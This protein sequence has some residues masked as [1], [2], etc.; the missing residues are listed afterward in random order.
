MK[1]PLTDLGLDCEKR[2]IPKYFKVG[3]EGNINYD[4]GYNEK[5]SE[6]QKAVLVIDEEKLRLELIPLIAQLVCEWEI[7]PRFGEGSD[8]SDLIIKFTKDLS[9]NAKSFIKICPA[10]KER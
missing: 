7:R 5:S 3:E 10:G 2:K 9:Q 6:N 8:R 4:R 1:I